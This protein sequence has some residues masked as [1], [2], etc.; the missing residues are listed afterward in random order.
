MT[1][2][3][4]KTIDF[5]LHQIAILNA[6]IGL[7]CTPKEKTHIL[8][9]INNHELAIKEINESFYNLIVPNYIEEPEWINEMNKNI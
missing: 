3:D 6:N 4:R 2:E 7:D 8:Y 5:H 9:M 1:S